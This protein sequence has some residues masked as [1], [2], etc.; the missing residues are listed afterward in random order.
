MEQDGYKQIYYTKSNDGWFKTLFL[1]EGR[2]LDQILAP[3]FLV[4]INAVVWTLVSE[5][6]ITE[7]GEANLEPY[8]SIFGLVLSSSL[9]FLLVF[10]LHR[11]AE[12]FW[13]SRMSWG[14]IIACIRAIVGGVLVHGR[15]NPSQRDE[16]LR[17]TTAFPIVLMHFMRGI[18]G[19]NS[20]TLLGVLNEDEIRSL[21]TLGHP[22]IHVAE[23][24]RR[25]LSEVFHFDEHT[26]INVAHGRSQR[27]DTLERE[28]N[29]LILEMGALER[30][31]TTPL[32]LV[33]V[34]HL[35]TFLLCFLLGLPYIWER[36][37]RYA[38]IPMVIM[39]AFAL[40]G[41]EGAAMECEAPFKKNRPNH[42]NMDAYCLT[43]LKNTLQEIQQN[44]DREISSKQQPV[45]KKESTQQAPDP[46]P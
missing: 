40:L 32:P 45:E 29:R 13:M 33:Y 10:R 46:N 4:S 41:L 16:V 15:H 9:S 27:I 6:Y 30:I 34:T 25:H 20:G 1:L 5:L 39:T 21:E 14:A 36:T 26:P 7:R 8:E 35:R 43:V 2:A 24:I 18:H 37:L 44:A 31:N 23:R 42:L 12:R 17:W 3:W 28:L 19:F 11:S 22:P 38:T